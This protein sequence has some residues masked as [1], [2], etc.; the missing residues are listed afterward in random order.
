[1]SQSLLGLPN[2]PMEPTSLAL[3]GSSGT[4]CVGDVF[5]PLDEN[6]ERRIK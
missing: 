1:M 5:N 6:K 2:N 4:L 3:G